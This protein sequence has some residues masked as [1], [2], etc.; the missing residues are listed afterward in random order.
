MLIKPAHLSPG[1]KVAVVTLSWGGPGAISIRYEAGKRQL[2]EEFGV[3]VVEMPHTLRS[4]DYVAAHPQARASDLMQAFADPM[5]KAIVSSIGGDDSVRLLPY[6]DLEVIRRNPKIFLGY[7][8]STITHMACFKAGITSFYGPS[9]MAGFAENAG[10]FPYMVDSLRRTLFDIKPPGEIKPNAEGWTVEH[11]KWE[12]PENQKRCRKLNPPDGPL[13]LQGSGTVRG[14]LIGG[15][16]EV[17]EFLKGTDYWPAP[18][19]WDGAIIFLENS[20]D[21]PPPNF[22]KYW[23]RNYGTQGILGRLNGILFGRPGGHLLNPATFV[24]YDNV[25]KQVVGQEFGR[26]DLPIFSRLDFGHTDPIF[27]LPYGVLAEMDC[28]KVRLSLLES[29]VS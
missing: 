4:P 9:I 8:D 25:L 16:S 20:E 13:C 3:E 29:G 11:L 22:F 1:D 10:M 18:E 28:E 7:S 6:L 27:T 15:C 19:I 2:A 26:P 17:L 5:V 21:M 24:E 23:L 14:R 12:D